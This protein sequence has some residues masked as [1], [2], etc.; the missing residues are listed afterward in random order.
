MWFL[1]GRDSSRPPAMYRYLGQDAINHVPTEN[2]PGY[3]I[4][5]FITIHIYTVGGGRNGVDG[6]WRV[7]FQGG[8]NDFRVVAVLL[9]HVTQELDAEDD[10]AGL[11][12]RY[13]RKAAAKTWEEAK[14]AIGLQNTALSG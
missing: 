5:R 13:R 9:N 7:F 3:F 14:L 4:L 10:V 2:S 11:V 1:K 8:M 12:T 6:G